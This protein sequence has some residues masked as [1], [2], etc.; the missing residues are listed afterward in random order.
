MK[1]VKAWIEKKS[2]LCCYCNSLYI[3]F[4]FQFVET[5]ASLTS[6]NLNELIGKSFLR[7]RKVEVNGIVFD[8][9]I[10]QKEKSIF[11]LNYAITIK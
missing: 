8:V 10:N 2:S 7:F 3:I 9:L 1:N 4:F 6:L 5:R 11:Q